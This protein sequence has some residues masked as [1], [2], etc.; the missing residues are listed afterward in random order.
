LHEPATQYGQGKVMPKDSSGS[1]A[2]WGTGIAS[3][4]RQQLVLIQA[5]PAG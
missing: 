2:N 4:D 3:D 5:V 1:G